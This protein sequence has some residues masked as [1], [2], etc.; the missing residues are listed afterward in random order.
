L[1]DRR[2][3]VAGSIA[4]AALPLRAAKAPPPPKVG[5]IRWPGP[6]HDL[7]GY[8]AIPAK[9]RGRQPAVL[10]LP[11]AGADRFALD[12]TDAL[13]LAGFVACVAKDPLSL[14][15]ALA[16]L[17]WLGTNAYSTG[18]VAAVGAGAGA[19]LIG[20]LAATPGGPLTCAVAFDGRTSGSDPHILHLPPLGPG[21]GSADYAGRW[22][23]AMDFLARNLA[24]TARR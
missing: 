14:D 15:E 1:P 11:D 18:K 10:V 13:A 5:A 3:F 22:R 24:M 8:M 6:G 2:A 9:A 4:L 16:S 17:R 12:L 21:G 23:E 19:A 20:P 7:H